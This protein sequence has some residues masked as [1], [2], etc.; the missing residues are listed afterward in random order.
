MSTLLQLNTSIFSA[1][2]QSSRLADAYVAGWQARNPGGNVI[3]RDF[4]RDPVPHLTAERFQA[5]LTKPEDRSAAH[6][7][8]VA[9]SD[10]LIG[11]LKRADVIVLGLPM[12]NF[13]VPSTLKAYFDH[14][15]RAGITFRYT[16]KGPVG[17]LAGKKAIVFAARG[18]MYS[19]TPRDTQTSYV[20][21]FFG[22]IGIADVE[23]VYAEG[24]S[25]GDAAKQAALEQAQGAIRRLHDRELAVA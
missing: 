3:V 25:M 17:L 5:F 9:L 2:G 22:F 19:G 24:L 11:E 10:E 20:R 14:V 7:A 6:D 21:D 16:E 15:G 18:G 13:G 1:G 12:Y 23:F 4:A 8:E